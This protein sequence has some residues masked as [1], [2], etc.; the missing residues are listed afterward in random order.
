MLVSVGT[1]R[2]HHLWCFDFLIGQNLYLS[3]AVAFSDH[4]LSTVPEG[5]DRLYGSRSSLGELHASGA[6]EVAIPVMV[7]ASGS[8]FL[9]LA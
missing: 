7:R 9:W 2:P 6:L 8:Y 3:K 1:W 5:A 4:F